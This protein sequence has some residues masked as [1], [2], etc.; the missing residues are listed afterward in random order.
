M[1]GPIEF[2]YYLR[3]F[4]LDDL[5]SG[6]QPIR[7]D[8]RM[9]APPALQYRYR[10]RVPNGSETTLQW[11]DWQAVPIVREGSEAFDVGQ[12]PVGDETVRQ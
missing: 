1:S 7:L 4:S 8:G 12:L 9:Y 11:S 5:A 2:R 10:E 3:A 6:A